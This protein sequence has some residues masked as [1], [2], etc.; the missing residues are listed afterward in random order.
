MLDAGYSMLDKDLFF[1]D[2]P[3]AENLTPETLRFVLRTP[4]LRVGSRFVLR[5]PTLRAGSRFVL[6]S[7]HPLGGALF[8]AWNLIFCNNSLLHYSSSR[9]GSAH[10]A[11]FFLHS[12]A[13]TEGVHFAAQGVTAL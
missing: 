10:S 6:R 7:P 11:A 1:P 9:V 4:T 5:S 13:K 3:P 8:A 12:F 2:P